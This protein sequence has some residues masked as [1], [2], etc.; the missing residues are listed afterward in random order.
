MI[1]AMKKI[2]LLYLC[3]LAW[4]GIDIVWVKKEKKKTHTHNHNI[5]TC[6]VMTKEDQE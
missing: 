4:R 5:F 3:D 2:S 1:E 6:P